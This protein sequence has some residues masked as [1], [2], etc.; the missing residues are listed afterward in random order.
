LELETDTFIQGASDPVPGDDLDG[1]TWDCQA[2]L[3]EAKDPA[4]EQRLFPWAKKLLI[5]AGADGAPNEEVFDRGTGSC[6]V[7]PGYTDEQLIEKGQKGDVVKP[8]RCELFPPGFNWE[9]QSRPSMIGPGPGS[10]D[11]THICIQENNISA[12]IEY[13]EYINQKYTS[14]SESYCSCPEYPVGIK[15]PPEVIDKVPN[16]TII[17]NETETGRIPREQLRGVR[18]GLRADSKGIKNN[19]DGGKEAGGDEK[20]GN[21]TAGRKDGKEEERLPQWG[22]AALA[23]ENIWVR[24]RYTDY[25]EVSWI[26]FR[27]GWNVCVCVVVEF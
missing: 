27:S 12:F 18:V 5:W 20:N 26:E 15:F 24:L 17:I 19:V 25:V 16:D 21:G 2:D 8:G 9:S 11:R 3:I 1:W 22:P 4:T 23:V 13:D 14:F 7:D 10:P 6:Y